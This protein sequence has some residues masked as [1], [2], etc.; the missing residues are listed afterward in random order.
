VQR[1]SGP[2]LAR[3]RRRLAGA[4]FKECVQTGTVVRFGLWANRSTSPSLGLYLFRE[5]TVLA[6]TPKPSTRSPSHLALPAGC[7]PQPRGTRIMEYVYI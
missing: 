2:H 6:A 7:A 3:W 4:N 1:Q 5:K